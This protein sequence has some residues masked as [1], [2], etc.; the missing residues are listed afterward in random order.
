MFTGLYARNLARE[1]NAHDQCPSG[2]TYGLL[3]KR[4]VMPR[5]HMGFHE[6]TQSHA[7]CHYRYS[8][9]DQQSTLRFHDTCHQ[10]AAPSKHN[11]C[12]HCAPEAELPLSRWPETLGFNSVQQRKNPGAQNQKSVLGHTSRHR[13][14]PNHYRHVRNCQDQHGDYC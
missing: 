7:H 10:S 6:P 1:Q 3:F 9:H 14:I 13:P 2:S 11:H 4:R 8:A 12:A 5:R